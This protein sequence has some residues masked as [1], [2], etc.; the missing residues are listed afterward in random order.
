[1]KNL[2]FLVLLLLS[3]GCNTQTRYTQQS[4]EIESIKSNIGNYVD[5]KWDEYAAHYAEGAT[6]FFNA[7]EES[8][9]S[10]QETI[11]AQKLSIEPLSS[12]SF[13]R[14]KDEYEMVVTDKGETWVN[15]WGLWKGTLAAN[16]KTFEIPVHLTYQFVDMKIVKAYGYWDSAPIQI[17]LMKLQEAAEMAET[18]VP[19]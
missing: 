1:M 17:E 19:Q 13:E 15:F 16:S 9:S 14:D 7:T 18:E 5:G 3:I 2:A 6:I 12:Y 10:I 11:A 8:P 4:P